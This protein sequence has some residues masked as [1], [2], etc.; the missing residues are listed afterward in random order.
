MDVWRGDSVICA[1]L[2]LLLL[3]LMLDYTFL[4]CSIYHSEIIL[5]SAVLTGR[6]KRREGSTAILI[7]P[8]D[9]M[10]TQSIDYRMLHM[11]CVVCLDSIDIS[12]CVYSVFIPH[13]A[14]MIV[15]V[16]PLLSC[17]EMPSQPYTLS[18]LM[19]CYSLLKKYR[20]PFALFS[21]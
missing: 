5:C 20:H 18:T 3:L 8:I 7:R 21:P 10:C 6:E 19:A 16:R 4:L 9:A 2:L 11:K 14:P 13:S 12:S 1:Q 15:L 17:S